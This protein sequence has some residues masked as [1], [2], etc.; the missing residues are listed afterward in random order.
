MALVIHELAT[1]SIKYG[2]LSSATGSINISCSDEHGD[3]IMVWT[4]KRGAAPLFV[5]ARLASVANSSIQAS[6]A[7][8]VDQL[9]SSGQRLA[10]SSPFE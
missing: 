5:K 2:S 9:L 3:V 7:S 10:L 1:N 6:L 4:E 8:W